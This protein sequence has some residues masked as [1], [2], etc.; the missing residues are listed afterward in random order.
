M[1]TVSTA[2]SI[3]AVSGRELRAVTPGQHVEFA[4]RLEEIERTKKDIVAP[5]SRFGLTNF[6]AG[7]K[8]FVAGEMGAAIYDIG[9]VAHRQIA[10]KVDVPQK[11]YDKMLCAAPELLATNVNHWLGQIGQSRAYTI[12]ILDDRIRA[13]LSDRY[14]ALD[15]FDLFIEATRRVSAAGGLISRLDLTEERF[16][17]RALAPDCVGKIERTVDRLSG[18]PAHTIDRNPDGS[19]TRPDDGDY[20]IAGIAISNSE[21][22]LGSLTCEAYALRLV[23]LNGMVASRALHRVHLGE[24]REHGLQ[25]SDATRELKDRAVW[26]EIGDT[27]TATFDREMFAD[28]IAAMNNAATETLEA[29]VEAVDIVVKHYGL[30]DDDRQ[31]MI[32]YLLAPP[33]AT[34]QGTSWGLI[35]AVTAL[36]RDRDA[37]RAIEIERM[38]GEL[39]DGAFRRELV[40]VAVR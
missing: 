26:S 10:E 37:D 39:L 22:G 8:G 32:N 25:I 17:F 36:G 16:F 38:G 34:E 5:A 28:M 27:I 13:V 19:W 14:R 11:Y 30:S 4:A 29:P 18:R 12:R 21:V 15:N 23:C 3:P 9:R 35:N 7:L 24:R 33:L 1:T 20:V 2:P 6:E 40:P 31:S